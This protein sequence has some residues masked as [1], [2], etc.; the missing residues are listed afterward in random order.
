M[1]IISS[2]VE[3]SISFR[4]NKMMINEDLLRTKN[5]K[6]LADIEG[7]FQIYVNKEMFFSDENILLLEYGVEISKWLQGFP[8]KNFNYSTMSHSEEPILQF[9]RQSEGWLLKSPWQKFQPHVLVSEDTLV[10]VLKQNLKELQEQ[11][12]EKYNLSIVDFY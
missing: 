12:N 5:R 3:V 8:K 9:I 10:R 1:D 6:L 7:E 4:F 11:M 2:E